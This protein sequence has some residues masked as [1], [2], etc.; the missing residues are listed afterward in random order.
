MD[1]SRV[2]GDLGDEQVAGL[3]GVGGPAGGDVSGV[4]HLTRLSRAAGRRCWTSGTSAGGRP[5]QPPGQVAGRVRRRSCRTR[6]G[7]RRSPRCGP[8]RWR[9]PGTT[10]SD[11]SR[12]T[13][14]PIRCDGERVA[15]SPPGCSRRPGRRGGSPPRAAA[16]RGRRRTGSRRP[17]GVRSKVSVQSSSGSRSTAS[18]TSVVAGQEP[19]AQLGPVGGR[20]A[21]SMS[22]SRASSDAVH[23]SSAR[24][25]SRPVQG[26]GEP[27][28]VQGQVRDHVRAGPV[29]AAGSA[30]ARP[31]S[32]RPS[33]VRTRRWVASGSSSKAP[34]GSR[35]VCSWGHPD[36]LVDHRRVGRRSPLP[37]NDRSTVGAA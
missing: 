37:G 8:G 34:W 20:P 3:A 18:A 24:P 36:P 22:P 19:V 28:G 7:R 14:A 13:I 33:T 4:G 12:L 31:S 17:P 29:R 25:R 5:G 1:I 21:S 35:S 30:R 15:T 2:D 26:A 9:A 27:L 23:A 16:C 10:S 6:R 11:G 32:S